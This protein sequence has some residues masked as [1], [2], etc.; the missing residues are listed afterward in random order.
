MPIKVQVLST[1]THPQGI[2]V[3]HEIVFMACA[4]QTFHFLSYALGKLQPSTSARMFQ[5]TN[6]TYDAWNSFG[7]F[8]SRNRVHIAIHGLNWPTQIR[9]SGQ[10]NQLSGPNW[11]LGTHVWSLSATDCF[12]YFRRKN[13][14][15]LSWNKFQ[16]VLETKRVYDA[17]KSFE[18]F[19]SS[20]RM[21]H[22]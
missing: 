15:K 22:H 9:L 5:T 19:M 11:Q 10:L 3:S 12:L 20:N 4:I 18:H 8:M 14:H 13:F 17:W 16:N 7:H 21:N 6:T 1:H 2:Y